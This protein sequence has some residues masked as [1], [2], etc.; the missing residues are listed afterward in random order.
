V[1]MREPPDTKVSFGQAWKRGQ[2][3][4]IPFGTEAR[5]V[6]SH[7]WQ[8]QHKHEINERL[9]R[10]RVPHEWEEDDLIVPESFDEVV[11]HVIDEVSGAA[12]APPPA[13]V[14]EMPE[15]AFCIHCGARWFPAARFCA[16]CGESA[17]GR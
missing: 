15:L 12:S 17:E 16:A 14:T 11:R 1:M 13:D 4:R 7:R 6:P 9:V 10:D 2:N 8:R 5:F 3:D